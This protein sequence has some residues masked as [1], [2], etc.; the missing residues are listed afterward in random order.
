MKVLVADQ[1][2]DAGLA[3]L[4]EHVEVDVRIGLS[5]PELLEAIG[6]YDGVV[7]RSA[8]TIDADVI[9]KADRLKVIARA[10]IGL[11][12]VDVPAATARGVIV[13]NAPQSNVISAAEHTVALLLALARSIPAA[14]TSLRSGEWK[15]SAFQGVELHGK[16]LGVIGLGRV[17]VLVA[18]RCSAFG[19]KLVAFDPYV[20]AERA[21]RMGVELVGSVADLCRV[22]DIVT[23]HL[24][25]TPET[26]GIVGAKELRLLHDRAL[27]VNTARGGIVDEEALHTALTEGWIGGA[28]LDVFSTEPITHSPLF[29]LP[30]VVVTPHL[31]ASTT[32]AQDKAGTMV[33]EAVVLA[34]NGE[35]VP[36]AVNVQIGAGIPE[37]VKPF[38]P[39]AETL[40]RVLTALQA[41]QG[42]DLTIEYVGR[43]AEEDTQAVTLSALKGAL[44]GVVHEPVTLVNAP[45]LASERGLRLS[46]VTSAASQDYVSLVRLSAGDVRL[47]GTLVGPKNTP[48][49]VDVWGFAVDMQPSDHMVFFRYVDRPGIVGIIGGRLGEAGVNIA[50]MQVGRREAGGEAL[51]AMTVDSAIPAEVVE[52]IRSGIGATD[53]RAIDL[54]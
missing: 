48:R 12:N 28:A 16:T 11:D 52:E 44:S 34:L 54:I 45:L 41:G 8:T 9:A 39:L 53:A 5:K 31:G 24:P 51:I 3:A 40:G 2:S 35:F 15:R 18:Q 4:A 37:A 26:V 20:S 42:D 36:S 29:A 6:A 25:R 13:C 14:D 17:G 19:M 33:A 10:G 21:A 32:E 30:N 22:A 7:V 1:L 49:L 38:M 47:A 27:V 50:S 23:V 46:T 43:V